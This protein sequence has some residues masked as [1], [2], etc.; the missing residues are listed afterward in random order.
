MSPMT[1]SS[2]SS[3]LAV[4]ARGAALS[5]A[6]YLRSAA[7]SRV[8]FT[9]K[10]DFHDPV[11]IHDTAVEAALRTIL[12]RAVPFSLILGE[13]AGGAVLDPRELPALPA[14]VAEPSGEEWEAARAA[15]LGFA[16]RVRWIVDPI[17]G[18]AN[19]AAGLPWFNTSIGVELDGRVVAGAVCAP[20]LFEVF[21]AD[22]ERAWCEGPAGTRP[23]EARGALEESEAVISSYYPGPRAF[24]RDAEAA[25][26]QERRIIAAYQST[27]RLGAAA[28]DLAYV[29]AG[30]LGAML[31]TNFK[32]W[33]VA[34][35]IHLVRVTGGRVVNLDLGTG[36][37][38]GLRPGVL[39]SG[40]DFEAPTA[41]AII[42][43]VEASWPR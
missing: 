23:L 16:G 9:T 36:L 42:A 13:E 31:G 5:V 8:G 1:T 14:G 21:I 17:D 10:T 3:A 6:A 26:D 4:L 32:P 22:E 35:G 15:L 34:A 24:A 40:R 28:L 2:P 27:R 39:A 11:T 38:D 12:G 19:F 43:E 33:D 18:T 37:A 41:R 7:A 29:A 20:L 25:L 30:R